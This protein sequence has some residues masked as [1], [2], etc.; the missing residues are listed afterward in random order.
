MLIQYFCLWQFTLAFVGELPYPNTA[1][2][3][4][5]ELVFMDPYCTK[6]FDEFLKKKH[7]EMH[8]LLECIM[9]RANHN[10]ERNI[11]TKTRNKKIGALN[12]TP[13]LNNVTLIKNNIPQTESPQEQT[14]LIDSPS[15]LSIVNDLLIKDL[16]ILSPDIN[17]WDELEKNID[18]EKRRRLSKKLNDSLYLFES[19]NVYSLGSFAFDKKNIDKDFLEN[20]QK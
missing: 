19:D 2:F 6:Y 7:P 17:E 14:F 9:E 12:N 8:N 11:E 20:L 18:T 15:F 1:I 10:I 16:T 3:Q 4:Y 5:W 13:G